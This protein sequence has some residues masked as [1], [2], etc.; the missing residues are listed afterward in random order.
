MNIN[1][2]NYQVTT[3]FYNPNPSPQTP[4]DPEPCCT[5]C[6]IHGPAAFTPHPPNWEPDSFFAALDAYDVCKQDSQ[7]KRLHNQPTRPYV[8]KG[9]ILEHCPIPNQASNGIHVGTHYDDPEDGQAFR[10]STSWDKYL[11]AQR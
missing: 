8:R 11:E 6:P 3:L 9:L 1:T 7:E 10:G 4:P 5:C 2:T